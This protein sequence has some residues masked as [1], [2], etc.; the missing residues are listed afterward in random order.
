MGKPVGSA[1][2]TTRWAWSK[3]T[4]DGIL[5]SGGLAEDQVKHAWQL[6]N[7]Y[8]PRHYIVMESDGK[9]KGR[10]TIESPGGM[11]LKLGQDMQRT[12][13]E[14]GPDGQTSRGNQTLNIQV[15]NGNLNIDCQNGD[16]NVI[17]RNINFTANGDDSKE[18]NFSV[19]ANNKISLDCQQY[20]YSSKQSITICAA[21][22]LR[23]QGTRELQLIGGITTMFTDSTRR[24]K[25]ADI[26]GPDFQVPAAYSQKVEDA[27]VAPERMGA[28]AI[29][30][31]E[32][33]A[34][35][36]AADTAETLANYTGV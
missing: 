7:A 20:V 22:M 3:Q 4:P 33:A 21:N 24:G 12:P 34:S 26:M 6:M 2:K 23:L 31:V 10:T 36:L 13:A 16:F 17:A 19:R 5:S 8:D 18:G 9:R 28:A 27:N 14:A 11:H 32:A 15:E 1:A 29:A 25:K 30:Q 35:A